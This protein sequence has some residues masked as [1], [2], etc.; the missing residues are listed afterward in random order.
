MRRLRNMAL[1]WAVLALWGCGPLILFG[2]GT[3]AGVA[4]IKF[5][6]G[7]LVV[8]FEAPFVE[9]WD[10]SLAAM[11]DLGF[12]IKNAEHGLTSGKIRASAGEDKPV[13]LSLAYKST[14]QTEVVIR[15]GVLGDEAASLKIK[16][17]IRD[18]LFGTPS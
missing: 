11:G 13:T 4:G 8:A 15:V 6:E 14:S 7:T 3:A 12:G 5:Y 9:T 2:A 17:K 16:D 1:L 18:R 10:A